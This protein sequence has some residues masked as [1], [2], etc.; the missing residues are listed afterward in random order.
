[1]N[2][3]HV[4]FHLYL[5]VHVLLSFLWFQT[6]IW[7]YKMEA[8]LCK[9]VQ[10]AHVVSISA[11]PRTH[12]GCK[13]LKLWCRSHTEDFFCDDFLAFSKYLIFFKRLK[14][15]KLNESWVWSEVSCQS[16]Y[17]HSFLHYDLLLKAFWALGI[18][19]LQSFKWPLENI[20]N[21]PHIQVIQIFSLAAF[22]CPLELH[23]T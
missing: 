20:G 4:C 13:C 17:W 11:I 15:H 19:W 6:R 22:P 5:Q 2:D 1:M 3:T 8:R 7:E 16:F 18:C 23:K 21:L 10:A 14:V 12:F 9:W